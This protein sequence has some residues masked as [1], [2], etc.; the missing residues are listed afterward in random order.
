MTIYIPQ[1]SFMDKYMTTAFAVNH[2]VTDSLPGMQ[3]DHQQIGNYLL[4]FMLPVSARLSW[5]LNASLR[6]CG[7][8]EFLQAAQA[9]S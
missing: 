2:Q 3:A 1:S 9:L 7:V 4:N 5:N 8:W 6:I